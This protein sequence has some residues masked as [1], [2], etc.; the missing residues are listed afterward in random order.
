MNFGKID[1]FILFGGSRLLAEFSKLLRERR[2]KFVIFTCRRQLNDIIYANTS[3]E[4]VLKKDGF[5][6]FETEDIN[7]DSRLPSLI[8]AN[9]LGIGLGEMWS[10][11]KPLLKKFNGRLV[12][13]MGIPLPHYRGGA[14]YT[15]QILRRDRVGA[16]NIQTID[17]FMVPAEFDSGAILKS[18]KYK[19]RETDRTPA[20]YFNTAASEE[21]VF[22]KEFLDDIAKGKDFKP[23]VLDEALS[24][25]FPRLY[26]P[27]HGFIDWS[28]NAADLDSFICAFDE[29]YAGTSTF[30]NGERVFLKN[31]SF[32]TSDGNFHPFQ[33]GLIYRKTSEGIYIAAV[34]GTLLVKRVTN[35]AG[36]DYMSFL[37]TGFRF[38][39][40]KKYL[41]D[42]MSFEAHYDSKKIKL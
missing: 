17:E 27:K 31:C 23:T 21:L 38:H 35:E 41:E 15:W 10:F 12:D 34:G 3:L 4:T 26:T 28:W 29:P 42:A 1:N 16:C 11:G 13:F 8:T 19:F 24:I 33:S 9:T 39:T 30:V 25:F 18:K 7:L 36:A 40:P 32:N 20:D 14:H 2:I 5:E 6:Y 22:L 37:K